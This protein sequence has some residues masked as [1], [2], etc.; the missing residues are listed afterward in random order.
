MN[1]LQIR[2]TNTLLPVDN[3][4]AVSLTANASGFTP[5]S[6]VAGCYHYDSRFLS[7]ACQA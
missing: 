1:K 2:I 6:S 3:A 7:R 4:D 5:L